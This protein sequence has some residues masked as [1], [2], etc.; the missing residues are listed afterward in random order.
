LGI[1]QQA[2]QQVLSLFAVLD[3][4]ED[5][6]EDVVN[7]AYHGLKKK[8]EKLLV[9]N[10]PAVTKQAR[11]AL[12][13]VEQAHNTL[14]NP[15]LRKLYK[16][17]YHSMEQGVAEYTH[18][19]LGQLCVTSGILTIDQ[20]KEAVEQQLRSGLALGEVLQEMQFISQ[21][22]L[23]GLLIGQQMI[24]APSA[25]SNPVALRL[26]SLN[27]LTEDMALIAQMEHR[28]QDRSVKE[29]V[30]RHKWVE[31]AVLDTILD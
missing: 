23:D 5:A 8:L 31:Q 3:V 25:V 22:E 19:R 24:D 20:L 11:K 29:I 1:L 16:A 2:G 18:P 14:L 7:E 21:A 12:Q 28:A 13:S 6:P 26:V 9:S 17:Q 4:Q 15:E 27:L 30:E 10:L